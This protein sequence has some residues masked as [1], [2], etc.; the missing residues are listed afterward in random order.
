MGL[1][2]VSKGWFE[3]L[4]SATNNLFL[5][6]KTKEEFYAFR[7]NYPDSIIYRYYYDWYYNPENKN[8]TRTRTVKIYNR[9]GSSYEIQQ[10]EYARIDSTYARWNPSTGTRITGD[11]ARWTSC[12]RCGWLKALWCCDWEYCAINGGKSGSCSSGDN[13]SCCNWQD[14]CDG[15]RNR[16]ENSDKANRYCS[17]NS[18]TC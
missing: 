1:R 3:Y 14:S 4:S 7:D 15:C 17:S 16:C 2:V 12:R 18:A 6:I 10:T 13:G 5:P 8:C 9:D 11:A